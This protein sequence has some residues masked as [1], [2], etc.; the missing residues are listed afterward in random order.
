MNK[1]DPAA[2]PYETRLDIK[3]KALELIDLKPVIDAS[4]IP[5]TTRL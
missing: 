3:F 2:F 4:P 5:G 1:T